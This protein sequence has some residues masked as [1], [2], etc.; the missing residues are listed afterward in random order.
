MGKLI[1]TMKVLPDSP[2]R[3]LDGLGRKVE[4]VLLKYGKIYKRSIEPIAF[5]INALIFAVLLDE[6]DTKGGTDPI[7]EDVKK[8]KGVQ[9]AQVT[10]ATKVADVDF[11]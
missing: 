3:D 10:D 6:E 2:E 5:G 11:K 8:V 9:D 7:E 1:V 4:D